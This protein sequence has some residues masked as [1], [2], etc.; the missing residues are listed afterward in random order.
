MA[1]PRA[2]AP[3][4]SCCCKSW[5]FEVCKAWSDQDLS[6]YSLKNSLG[7]HILGCEHP[8]AWASSHGLLL[9]GLLDIKNPFPVA[10]ETKE[11]MTSWVHAYKPFSLSLLTRQL[12]LVLLDHHYGGRA[13]TQSPRAASA[14]LYLGQSNSQLVTI[15]DMQTS[16]RFSLSNQDS[17]GWLGNLL[18]KEFLVVAT[19]VFCASCSQDIEK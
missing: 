10:L 19:M 2:V 8:I 16:A 13:V 3:I 1:A 11:I 18:G 12:F 15:G 9:S 7:L 5:V 14:I 6:Y 17:Q 4:V